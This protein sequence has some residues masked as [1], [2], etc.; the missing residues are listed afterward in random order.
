MKRIARLTLSMLVL[1]SI[2]S[3]QVP[4]TIAVFGDEA[5]SDC[6]IIDAPGLVH[7]YVFHLGSDGTLASQFMLQLNGGASLIHVTDIF[8][9]GLQLGTTVTGVAFS[10]Q[11]CLASPIYLADVLWTGTGTSPACSTID[12]VADPVAIT[13]TIEV[14]DCALVKHIGA[15]GSVVVNGNPVDCR[16][17][18]AIEETT[19]GKLKSLYE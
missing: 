17:D 16:C 7:A 3:A 8:K 1:A 18:R 12:V 6:Y 19:W 14:V 13:G 4:G 9:V 2:A 15:G 10:Y 11:A 5:N